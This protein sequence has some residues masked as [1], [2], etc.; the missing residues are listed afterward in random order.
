MAEV[1]SDVVDTPSA[2]EMSQAHWHYRV[3]GQ[4]LCSNVPL[5]ESSRDTF[6]KRDIVFRYFPPEG[7]RVLEHGDTRLLTRGNTDFG[8]F[9]SLC[10]T[11]QGFLVSWEGLC[12]YLVSG[13][14]RQIQCQPCSNIDIGWTLN[15][16]YTAVLSFALQI[17]GVSNFHA[18][19]VALPGGAAGF[20][21]DPGSGKSTLAAAFAMEGYPFLTDDIL[22][23]NEDSGQYS[24]YPGIL[25]V[26]LSSQSLDSLFGPMGGPPRISENGR[27]Q[28]LAVQ[29]LR[30]P[31]SRE[32]I[33]LKALFALDRGGSAQKVQI[34][35][36]PRAEALRCLLDNTNCLPLLP[37]E[38]LRRHMAFA[39]RLT[40]SVPVYR[41][42]YPSSLKSIRKVIT[43]ILEH[44]AVVESPA[45]K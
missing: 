17:R 8:C 7:T 5:L 24:A 2:N 29:D 16:L 44:S 11:D 4:R 3:Y 43:E 28:R 15:I 40:D 45:E 1:K 39:A 35:S 26:S 38:H 9:L 25:N 13:D 33:P 30:I 20:M 14:G 21:G 19:A 42:G 10:D 31:F 12:D 36:L 6:T 27:K 37:Q 23:L 34:K 41:L 18:S 22:A 32:P